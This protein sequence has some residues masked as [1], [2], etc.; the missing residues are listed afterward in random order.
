MTGTQCFSIVHNAQKI[1][2]NR[3]TLAKLAEIVYKSYTGFCRFFCVIHILP[4]HLEMWEL[5]LYLSHRV[6]FY[7]LDTPGT[8]RSA[9]SLNGFFSEIGLVKISQSLSTVSGVKLPTPM[10]IS[11]RHWQSF[12]LNLSHIYIC[13]KFEYLN[14]FNLNYTVWQKQQTGWLWSASAAYDPC[15]QWAVRRN[16]QQQNSTL[17]SAA[18]IVQTWYC[19]D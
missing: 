1:V 18:P 13:V 4:I 5:M 17:S 12:M 7:M 19:W 9:K 14:F 15:S 11:V 8:Y 2:Y 16:N 10:S 3:D 6:I